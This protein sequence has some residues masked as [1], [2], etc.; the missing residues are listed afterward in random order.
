M[1]AKFICVQC[2]TP[3]TQKMEKTCWLMRHGKT[4]MNLDNIC[5]GSIDEPL[6]D[7]GRKQARDSAKVFSQNAKPD[8]ILSSPMK[9]AHETAEIF[10]S[11]FR[12]QKNILILIDIRLRERCVGEIEGRPETLES[13]AKL[14][15]PDFLPLGATPLAEF[16]IETQEL[17][18]CFRILSFKKTLIV[19]HSFRMLTIIKLIKKLS[20]EQI[21]DYPVPGNCQIT[22]FGVAPPCPCGSFFYEKTE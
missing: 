12:K 10:S 5:I 6:N 8:V 14:F 1:S 16:E 9:R 4:Q 20:V 13:D 21:M 17:I 18:N 15:L 19:T 3:T 7:L 11:S 22:T 2:G